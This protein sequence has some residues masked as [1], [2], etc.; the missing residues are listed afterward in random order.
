[1][2]E[3]FYRSGFFKSCKTTSKLR[4]RTETVSRTNNVGQAP[5][6]E[7][8][9]KS[10]LSASLRLGPPMTALRFGPHR[11]HP[12]LRNPLFRTVPFVE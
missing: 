3:L 10:D 12:I 7:C 6:F 9:E 8:A 2:L 5:N 11:P 1:M 4:S